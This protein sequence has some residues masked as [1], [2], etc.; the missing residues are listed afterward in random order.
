MLRD[1]YA[2]MHV[3]LCVC[4]SVPAS[5]HEDWLPPPVP[6]ME[7]Q[8]V[9]ATLGGGGCEAEASMGLSLT[10]SHDSKLQCQ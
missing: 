6:R 2:C 3:F 8:R 9:M 4:A 5:E 1:M 7:V 10:S